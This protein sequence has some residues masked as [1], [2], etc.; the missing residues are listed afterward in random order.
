MT[1]EPPAPQSTTPSPADGQPAPDRSK[2]LGALAIYLGILLALCLTALVLH[3]RGLLSA[4]PSDADVIESV[5]IAVDSGVIDTAVFG[6]EVGVREVSVVR[7]IETEG[8][9]S[10]HYIVRVDLLVTDEQ[11]QVHEDTYLEREVVLLRD[12]HGGFEAMAA[13]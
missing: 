8:H 1:L 9:D 10:W 13:P 5:R 11:G 4:G 2:G 7:P 6:D 3:D 12:G